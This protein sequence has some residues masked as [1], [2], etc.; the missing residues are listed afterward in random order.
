MF[1]KKSLEFEVYTR[2]SG[3]SAA[4]KLRREQLIPAVVYGPKQKTIPLSLDIKSVEKY[5]KKEY[6]NKIFTFKSNET[7]LNGLKVLKKD[8][9]FHKLTRKPLHMDFLSL[10]MSKAVRINVEVVFTG[11][12]KGVKESGGLF[13][14]IRRTV[15]IECLPSEIPDSLSIDV[16]PLDINQ[17][18]HVSDLDIPE[19]IKLITSPKSS[20]CVVNEIAE[21][22]EEESKSETE[23]QKEADSPPKEEAQPAADKK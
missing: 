16:S 2:P 7:H 11:K 6:D 21:E 13:N 19:N 3:T 12:A 8:I 22:K 4:R 14:I 10:D 18:F 1:E 5:A 20:L 9:S 17:N 23:E 15:E